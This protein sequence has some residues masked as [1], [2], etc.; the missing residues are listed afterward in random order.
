ME[1][2]PADKFPRRYFLPILPG[3]EIYVPELSRNRA[4]GELR[5]TLFPFGTFL[6]A[7]AKAYPVLGG[8][9]QIDIE[10]QGWDSCYVNNERRVTQ[11][12]EKNEERKRERER[13]RERE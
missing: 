1:P 8:C 6:L 5:R 12:R 4:H 2:R 9:L 13:E 7:I 3:P 10:N 11:I